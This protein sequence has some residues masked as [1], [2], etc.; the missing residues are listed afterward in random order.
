M[1]AWSEANVYR[2]AKAGWCPMTWT[3]WGRGEWS[4]LLRLDDAGQLV[5]KTLMICWPR[6]FG[7]TEGIAVYQLMRMDRYPD[8]V[9]IV[10]ANSAD[11]AKDTVLGMAMDMVLHSPKLLARVRTN[12]GQLVNVKGDIVLTEEGIF[13]DNGSC[14]RIQTTATRGEQGATSGVGKRISVYNNTEGCKARSPAMMLEMGVSCSD[15]WNGL[16]ACDSNMGDVDN[17]V[18]DF[19][20]KGQQA[21]AERMSAIAESRPGNLSIGDPSVGVSYVY[22][23]DLD[24]MLT[25]GIAM[26]PWIDPATVRGNYAKM[27]AGQFA[28]NILNKASG[29]GDEIWSA[30]QIDPLFVSGI[31]DVLPPSIIPEFARRFGGEGRLAI[32]V[33]LDRAGAFSKTPDR[34]V[35]TATGRFTVPALVGKPRPVYDAKGK[36]IGEEVTDG[37]FYCLVGAWEFMHALGDPIRDKIRQID[38]AYGIG[39]VNL[40]AY[41]ASDLGEWCK[42]QRFASRSNIVHM[43]A[44]A[45]QQLVTFADG[46]VKTRRLILPAGQVIL[47]AEFLSYREDA[48]G[49]GVPSYSG[50]RK[51]VEL[52]KDG[53][54]FTTW[55]KDDY[56]ES[57]LWSLDAAR[58]APTVHRAVMMDKPAGW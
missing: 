5:Y 28:R 11:Q 9:C 32:G 3:P 51:T 24:D 50:I 1:F 48:S 15:A 55:I 57:F 4:R 43:T 40:E 58:T 30:E 21:E 29:S 14:L 49:G 34:S 33:G 25:R 39:A 19:V 2:N 56:L 53:K 20:A 44:Q 18:S 16:V 31:P 47:R 13:F 36:A 17:F 10:Q 6:R 8:Q 46:L 45:R 12:S 26:A 22:F 7:K 35:I 38:Q 23:N 52:E 37:T 27:T 41:Q 54:R 42:T